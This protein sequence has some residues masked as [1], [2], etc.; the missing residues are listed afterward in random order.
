M[1]VTLVLTHQCNLACD[2]CFA[3]PKF[4]RTMP[5]ELAA[6]AVRLAFQQDPS[7]VIFFGGEPLLEFP[8]MARVTRLATRLAARSRRQLALSL[9]TN[10]TL[11][12][13]RQLHFLRHYRFHV[14]V[15]LDGVGE[16]QD[17]HRP[18]VS[19]RSSSGVVWR[20]LERA[21]RSLDHLHVMAVVNPDTLEG[22]PGLAER[23]YRLGLP[24]LSLLP[25]HE[26]DWNQAARERARQVYLELARVCY[27]SLLTSEPFSITPFAQRHPV[28]PL[29]LAPCS[30]GES[31]LS[32]S[33]RGNL[34][35]CSRLVHTD[36][37]REARIG[38]LES[39]PDRARV[40]ALKSC[41]SEGCR[42]LA[43]AP[44]PRDRALDNQSFFRR[45]AEEASQSA[46]RWLTDVRQPA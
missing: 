36:T 12:G 13:P 41:P 43:L 23:L 39:G 44:G 17:R 9:T 16:N 7:G 30:F 4:A 21:T 1:Y 5:Y 31:E 32:V 38:T 29:P 10:A 27:A 26:A 8:L 6:R 34:Y 18:F 40:A 14:A 24:S 3:G 20:N 25:N 42:C 2:Y 19:G 37:N 46:W 28:R 33:P 22:L 35:P 15:S 45:L 11:L